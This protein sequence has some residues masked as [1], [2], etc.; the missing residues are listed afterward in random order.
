[1]YQMLIFLVKYIFYIEF[2]VFY[3]LLRVYGLA[4]LEMCKL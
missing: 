2:Q 4:E 3:I 1:M